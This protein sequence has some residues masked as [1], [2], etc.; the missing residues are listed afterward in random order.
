[1]AAGTDFSWARRAMYAAFVFALA[2]MLLYP[3]GTLRD[4]TTTGYSFSRNFISDLGNTV[5]F[6]GQPNNPSAVLAMASAATVVAAI[7]LATIGFVRLL[8]A[9]RAARTLARAA[10]V[11]GAVACLAVV[12]VALAPGNRSLLLHVLFGQTASG[13]IGLSALL[14]ALASLRD[15]RFTKGVPA[16]WLALA[17]VVAALFLVR[18]GGPGITTDEGLVFHVVKQKIVA[19]VILLIFIYQ[20]RQADRVARATDDRRVAGSPNAATPGAGNS[21]P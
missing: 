9:A 10:G 20:T 14:L 19:V 6:G 21:C 13:A 16:A 17:I 3:G 1:M 11:G 4:P 2:A 12:G 18:W 15:G 7:L 8:S 5:S